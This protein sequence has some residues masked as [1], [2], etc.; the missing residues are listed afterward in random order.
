MS[1]TPSDLPRPVVIVAALEREIKPLAAALDGG[2]SRQV[3]AWEFW[4][5][6]LAGRIV[7]A[8]HSGCG[9]V[10]A[11]ALTQLM[12]GQ[13]RPVF[14]VHYGLAGA[15]SPEV[16]S[17]DI[18]LGEKSIEIDYCEKM[19]P[20]EPKPEARPDPD[21]LSGF[22]H[23]FDAAGLAYKRGT[24]VCQ[25]ADVVDKHEKTHLWTTYDG[26][27]TCW[28]GAAVGR[29][30][31]LNGVAY[32]QLRGVTDLADD[33]AGATAA[34]FARAAGVSERLVGYLECGLASAGSG[35]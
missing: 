1:S 19:L 32:I 7:I 4:R 10:R 17:G 34:F 35:S 25:D 27:C 8:A 30:C 29:I 22:A 24:I 12:I 9:K 31:N 6:R 16:E 3:S 33:Q 23:A 20:D 26:L 15:V 14:I 2:T 28:E 11:A 13:H 21:L 18:I 5:G